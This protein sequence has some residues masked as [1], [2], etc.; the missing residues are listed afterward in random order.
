MFPLDAIASQIS[1]K[2]RFWCLE[3]LQSPTEISSRLKKINTSPAGR[4]NSFEFSSVRCLIKNLAYLP[5]S[6]CE[7]FYDQLTSLPA[8][9]IPGHLSALGGFTGLSSEQP[10]SLCFFYYNVMPRALVLQLGLCQEIFFL[11]LWIPSSD[12]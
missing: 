3:W 12:R 4:S 9:F 10:G 6:H 2:E 7:H 11:K 5:H 1:M 8:S